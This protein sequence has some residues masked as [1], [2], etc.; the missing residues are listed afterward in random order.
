MV[1]PKERMENALK[2]NEPIDYIPTFDEDFELA[3][4]V[5]KEFYHL[6]W[7]DSSRTQCNY[8][9]L[10]LGKINKE[11]YEFTDVYLNLSSKEKDKLL[12]DEAETYI[13]LAEKYEWAGIEIWLG[14]LDDRYIEDE[15]KVIKEIKRISGE[16]YFI[17]A[18]M[19]FGTMAIPSTNEAILEIAVLVKEKPWVLKERLNKL[20]QKSLIRARRLIDAGCDGILEVADYSTDMGLFFPPKVFKE[21]V[22]PNLFKISEK[23]KKWGA[24]FIKHTDG[25][26]MEVFDDII[27]CEPSAIHSLQKTGKMD[28]QLI[29]QKTKNKVCI[30]GNVSTRI[31][32][33]GTIEEIEKETVRSIKELASGGG[34]ILA[35]DN[36]V[37]KGIPVENYEAL[38]NIWK[39]LRSLKY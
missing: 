23:I 25:D 2:L 30:L 18:C 27:K 9:N 31:L 3:E 16:K 37:F 36:C 14:A 19:N 34:Y 39:R 21:F 13:A 7:M 38:I 4:S 6:S 15:I 35:V 28:M 17:Q 20:M 22:V 8:D 24:Y 29:R 5:G 26:C 11:K 10:L 33:T 12:V 32:E 1:S